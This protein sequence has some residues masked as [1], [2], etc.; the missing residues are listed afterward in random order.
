MAKRSAAEEM[1]EEHADRAQ[2]ALHVARE[3]VELR[4]QNSPQRHS[5]NGFSGTSRRSDS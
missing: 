5:K 4:K 2:R 1:S 3:E